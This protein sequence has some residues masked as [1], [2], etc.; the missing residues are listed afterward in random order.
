MGTHLS[1]IFGVN[2]TDLVFSQSEGVGLPVREKALEM[3]N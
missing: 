1:L 2:F 3:L